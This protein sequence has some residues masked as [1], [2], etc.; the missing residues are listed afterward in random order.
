M[1]KLSIV[2]IREKYFLAKNFLSKKY[3]KWMY[4]HEVNKS[5]SFPLD[6][7]CGHG[8]SLPHGCHGVFIS[9]GAK[10]GENATIFQGVTIGSNT[11]SGTKNPGSPTIGDNVFIGAGAKIIGGV[12]VG[13]N[14]RIGANAVVIDDIED[15]STVVLE[16]PRVISH[17]DMKENRFIPINQYNG[18]LQ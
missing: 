18:D 7:E 2:E 14:V 6:V 15:N 10:I 8:L 1:K 9:G 13:N 16:R 12:K 11:L 5:G 17:S 3:Y 4:Y